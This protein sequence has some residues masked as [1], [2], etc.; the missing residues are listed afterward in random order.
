MATIRGKESCSSRLDPAMEVREQMPLSAKGMVV[1]VCKGEGL[2]LS[3]PLL[4]SPAACLTQLRCALLRF[5]PGCCLCMLLC[6]SIRHA[7]A[8]FMLE[9]EKDNVEL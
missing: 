9:T 8:R 7:A 6:C 3:A 4:G 1:F 2:L 5:L